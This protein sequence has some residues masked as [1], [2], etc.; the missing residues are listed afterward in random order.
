M[1]H[2]LSWYSLKESGGGRERNGGKYLIYMATE[3][4]M[5]GNGINTPGLEDNGVP[6]GDREA[7]G[8]RYMH[9]F[10][11]RQERVEGEGE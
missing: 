1:H 6:V 7:N 9:F 3:K 4:G 2:G 8:I 5:W 10:T 11:A